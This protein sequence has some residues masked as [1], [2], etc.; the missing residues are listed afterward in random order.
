MRGIVQSDARLGS[1]FPMIP[2]L[3]SLVNWLEGSKGL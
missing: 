2:N 3:L 1:N